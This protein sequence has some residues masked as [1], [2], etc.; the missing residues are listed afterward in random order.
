M[1]VLNDERILLTGGSGFIGKHIIEYFNNNVVNAE[2]KN[3]KF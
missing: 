2:F 1:I 3:T